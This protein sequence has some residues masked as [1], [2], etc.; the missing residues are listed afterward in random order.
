MSY[1]QMVYIT[2]SLLFLY[3]KTNIYATDCIEHNEN[4]WL[5]II[6]EGKADSNHEELDYAIACLYVG[7][8]MSLQY[9]P[10]YLTSVEELNKIYARNESIKKRVYEIIPAFLNSEIPDI[11]CQAARALAFYKW[12]DSFD[13]MIECDSN[14]A[15]LSILVILGDERAVPIIIDKYEIAISSEV[16]R[17]RS[18]KDIDEDAA[19]CIAA[20]YHFAS[21]KILP[22]IN[23]VIESYP[24]GEIGMMA[25]KVRDRIFEL[26]PKTKK[27]EQ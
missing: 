5:E 25:K 27:A 15:Y 19:R 9:Y 6:A 12:E 26:Y 23:R 21:P 16:S 24:E 18:Q 13:Y 14:E 1:K 22:F 7:T 8:I 4:E 17:Y 3:L 2:I 20:L 11:S 10:D